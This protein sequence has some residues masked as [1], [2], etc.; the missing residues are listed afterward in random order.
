MWYAPLNVVRFYSFLN[1]L[2]IATCLAQL[3][4]P[5]VT[6]QT[7]FSDEHILAILNAPQL[8]HNFALSGLSWSIRIF[9]PNK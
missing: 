5:R 2:P 7:L 1:S 9:T 3:A 4:D 6:T 8:Q